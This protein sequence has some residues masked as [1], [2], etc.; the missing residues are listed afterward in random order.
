MRLE[1]AEQIARTI[2]GE[3]SGFCTRSEIAGSIRRRRAEVADIDLVVLPKS[4]SAREA[5]MERCGR[6]AKLIKGGEQY[7]V[8]E[9]ANG[10]Q[11][12]LWFAHSGT[13]D[14]FAPDPGNFGV[15][16]LARTGS[17]MFN[18]WIA[19]KARSLGLHFNPH[20]GIL[21]RN[22]IVA[23][24]DEADIFRVLQLDPIRPENRER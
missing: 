9:L 4:P 1:Q 3:L 13:A 7:V 23:S 17:A 21:R 15:L 12:D 10:F 22:E 19:D 24:I 20:R 2:D 11:L 5:I 18:V 6:R 14:L 8:F 16:L